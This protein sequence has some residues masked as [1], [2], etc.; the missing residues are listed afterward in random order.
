MRECQIIKMRENKNEGSNKM[1]LGSY[2]IGRPAFRDL[3]YYLV[4]EMSLV[5]MK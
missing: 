1:C 3:I 2:L 4:M 5:H